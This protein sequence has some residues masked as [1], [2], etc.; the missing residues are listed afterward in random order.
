M[1]CPLE[2]G[3]S[4]DYINPHVR[5]RNS[6]QPLVQDGAH[7]RMALRILGVSCAIFMGTWVLTGGKDAAPATTT[8]AF[9]KIIWL[10]GVPCTEVNSAIVTQIKAMGSYTLGSVTSAAIQANHTSGVGQIESV[11]FT[12]TPTSVILGCYVQ[13]T[14]VSA[15]WYS[16]FDN[17]INFC[18]LRNVIKGSGL[19]KAPGFLEF[20]N[21]WLCLGCGFS[22][23]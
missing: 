2:A 14:S 23:C 11:N 18:N 15:V 16:L 7:S 13:G 8:S 22:A 3:R 9:C 20:T 21:E 4:E 1:V 17:G 19:Y 10:I 6:V 5:N 12:M